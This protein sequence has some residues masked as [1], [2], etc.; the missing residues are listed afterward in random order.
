MSTK[1]LVKKYK[2]LEPLA[3]GGMATVYLAKNLATD[4]IVV[5]KIPNFTGL[6][7]RDKLEKRFIREA[8][9]LSKINSKYVVT[10]HD[11][12]QDEETGEFF[13]ILEYLHGKTIEEITT[14]KERIPIPTVVDL[15]TQIAQVLNDLYN[16]CIIHRD[17]KSSN[18]KI[19]S[20]GNIKLFDFG[21]SKGKDLPAMTRSSDFLG[22]LQYMSPEQA[23][24]RDVDIRS[25]IY[26][27]G[28]VIYEMLFGKLPFDAPSPV[29]VLEMQ[30]KQ[31]PIIP[32]DAHSRGI[33]TS[34]LSLMLRCMSKNPEDRY[35]T[36]AELINALE[37]VSN[38]LGISEKER[39]N[40]RKTRLTKI[41]QSSVPTYVYRRNK[42]RNTVVAIVVAGV[43]ALGGFLF[44]M[45]GCSK[46]V[47]PDF[48]VVQ[49]Q[50]TEYQLL[51]SKPPNVEDVV[52]KVTE[53]P[54]ELIVSLERDD[55]EKSTWTLST[56]A[57]FKTPLDI[58]E[59]KLD[60]EY[61]KE[62]NL[63]E[64]DNQPFFVK[65]VEGNIGSKVMKIV[66]LEEIQND[67]NATIEDAVLIDGQ[68]YVPATQIGK[69][70]SSTTQLD[71]ENRTMTVSDADRTTKIID[72]EKYVLID[73]E[74]QDI[75]DAPTMIKDDMILSDETAEELFNIDVET[76]EE[77]GSVEILYIE[78]DETLSTITFKAINEEELAINGAEIYFDNNFKGLTPL[79]NMK[80]P[81]GT[82][83]I[84]I[85]MEGYEDSSDTL[86]LDSQQRMTKEYV[87]K[88]IPKDK[89]E[90][91]EPKYGTLSVS[92]NVP[93]GDFIVDG[94]KYVNRTNLTLEDLPV[95]NHTVTFRLVGFQDKTQTLT[96]RDGETTV[97]DFKVNSGI[98]KVR[99]NEPAIVYVDNR[100]LGDI[101]TPYDREV[102]A[103]TYNIRVDKTNY[104]D[105]V[106]GERPT[107]R[108]LTIKK[109][110]TN[111]ITFELVKKE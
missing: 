89:P 44:A 67:S 78:P 65:V 81:N 97:Y 102:A 45:R 72:G 38:E 82:Y 31:D 86:T 54:E 91:E 37:S 40:L 36:P 110:L 27:A 83:N 14:S 111:T 34:L 4:E 92:V 104:V 15:S 103:K 28:I 10:I 5:A 48:E 55:E 87:L 85:K 98:L 62:G 64:T 70:T 12:G 71:K 107:N 109:G 108:T 22:T 39:T 79:N 77:E 84:S 6:P 68:T 88:S 42:K 8:K 90:P 21:I 26:S 52:A 7:N 51:L 80:L 73:G 74:K 47:E 50:T 24:G 3:S 94:K 69:V 33:P 49:G 29:E 1:V 20:E 17:I 2:I 43:I 30:R 32:S 35:Q 57:K 41:S 19:T 95:G 9:I 18:I 16:Q 59:V 60:I 101:Q 46:P 13:L 53:V 93:W 25:D 58:Y 99:C 106:T 23:D 63:A 61:I 96:I 75:K 105:P 56:F 76:N 100:L 11:Y 66:S